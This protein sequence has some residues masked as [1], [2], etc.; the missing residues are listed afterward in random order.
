MSSKMHLL[1]HSVATRIPSRIL[2]LILKESRINTKRSIDDTKDAINE[3]ASS[4]E[5]KDKEKIESLF[6]AYEQFILFGDKTVSIKTLKEKIINKIEARAKDILVDLPFTEINYP[7]VDDNSDDRLEHTPKLIKTDLVSDG[8]LL[9]YASIKVLEETIELDETYFQ[10]LN[11]GF[12]LPDELYDIKAKRHIKRR[13]YD[14]VYISFS[15]QTIEFRLDTASL[16]SKQAIEESFA[17]LEKSF[18]DT[19]EKV[20]PSE[21]LEFENENLFLAVPGG[22]ENSKLRVCELGFIVGSV[23]HHEKMRTGTKDLR[24]ELF[25]KGGKSSL[26]QSQTAL[27]PFR[28]ALRKRRTLTTVEGSYETEAYLPGTAKLIQTG[29]MPVLDYVILSNCKTEMDYTDHIISIKN[30][31]STYRTRLLAA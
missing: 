12:T 24:N 27:Q 17:Y 20:I 28:I 7:F 1:A 29:G 3:L 25:H 14:S 13:Y 21:N 22:Y 2:R 5:L 10:Q 30:D 4:C 31:I 11:A 6:R 19:I 15:D 16:S 23:I 18:R 9:T 26:A 8:L